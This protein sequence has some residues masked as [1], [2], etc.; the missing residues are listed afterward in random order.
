MSSIIVTIYPPQ[1][2]NHACYIHTGLFELENDNFLKTTIAFSFKKRLGTIKIIDSKIRTTNQPHPKTSFYKLTDK[3]NNKTIHFA[4]DLYDAS[5]SFSTYALENCEYVF[6]RNYEKKYIE[7]LPDAYQKK[8]FPLGLSFPSKSI[9][10]KGSY[11][12]FLS[13]LFTNLLISAK[14]DRLF[15]KR[16]QNAYKEQINH[17][18]F[19]KKTRFLSEFEKFSSSVKNTILFQTRCFPNEIDQDVKQIHQQRYDLVLLL[20]KTFKEKFKG[21][22][23]PSI[24]ANENYKKALSNFDSDPLQYLNLLKEAKIVI[25][26]RGLV[27]SPAWKMAEYLSQA[28]VIIAEKLTAELPFPIT[29]GKEVLFFD[30]DLELVSQIEKVLKNEVLCVSLAKNSRE[31]FDMHVHPKQNVKRIINFMKAIR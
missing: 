8:I 13:L 4:T 6:K 11:K 5:F 2:L 3:E 26:T 17:W 19:F 7:L 12:F 27:N 22:I 1:E 20:K 25:Y 28:K 21:G 23:I 30:S 18:Y 10:S 29:N 16:L 14:M 15:F 24:V 9:H 31:Y